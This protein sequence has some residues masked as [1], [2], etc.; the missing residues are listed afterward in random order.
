MPKKGENPSSNREAVILRGA[1][2][3]TNEGFVTI[4][5][6]H[7]V[8][9]FNKAAEKI[10]GYSREEVIGKDLGLILSPGCEQ[11]HKQAVS[12]FLETRKSKLIGHQTEFQ[13]I[14]KS[15]EKFPLSISFSV[16]E[17]E[18]RLYFT[19]IIRDLS[20][21]KALQEQVAQSERLAA[22]GQLVA[23]IT[24]EI[25]NPLIMIGG[26]ARQLS[27]TIQD[28]KSQSKLKIIS[29]E[30]QRLEN[31]I[32]ELKEVYRPQKLTF[33]KVNIS[34]LLKEIFSLSK[35][36][37]KVAGITLQLETDEDPLFVEGEAGKLKQVFLNLV[38]NAME[39]ME[40]G[41]SLTIR[42]RR[43]AGRVEISI[44]DNGPGIQSKDREKLFTPF[45][46]T[47]PQGTGLGLVVSKKIIE[48]HPGGTLGLESEEGKGTIV[49]I[50][51]PLIKDAEGM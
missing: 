16:S 20:E 9:I 49:K 31:L 45:F 18:G 2:E 25:K 29:D 19:G 21:T 32:L 13:S 44:S 11:G 8:I 39:A 50:S 41:G 14:R 48:E 24:H 3:N 46:T 4:D 34:T 30:V 37:C 17:V 36:D 28:E 6:H 22:L 47:K 7:Q 43:S 12:R 15:G 35:E 1:T 51:L 23:E 38:K 42:S 10:F 5:E 40:K 26:F 27:R 33:E